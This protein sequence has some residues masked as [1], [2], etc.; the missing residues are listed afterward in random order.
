MYCAARRDGDRLRPAG[1]GCTKKVKDLFAERGIPASQRALVPVLRDESGL[2]AVVGFGQD[3]R[4]IPRSGGR[5]LVIR[6]LRSG[7][8]TT[9]NLLHGVGDE[10]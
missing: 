6:A 3:E 5:L 7:A 10:V 8:G 2:L 9:S 4:T 1:R